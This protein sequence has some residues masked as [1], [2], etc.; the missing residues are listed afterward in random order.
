[1]TAVLSIGTN[2][3]RFSP[4]SRVNFDLDSPWIRT[5]VNIY[6][7][8]KIYLRSTYSFAFLIVTDD[9]TIEIKLT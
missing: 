7:L 6:F 2:F 1:M 4:A 5:S 8:H 9:A 3:G